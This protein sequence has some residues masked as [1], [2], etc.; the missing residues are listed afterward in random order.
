MSFK[1]SKLVKRIIFFLFFLFMTDM[2]KANFESWLTYNEGSVVETFT[3]ENSLSNKKNESGIFINVEETLEF[4]FNVP[5]DGL[6]TMVLEYKIN[7][8]RV[9]STIISISWENKEL[10]SYLPALWADESKE[11]PRDR[12]GNEIVPRQ[13]KIDNFH[14]EYIKDYSSLSSLPY[15]FELKKGKNSFKVKNISQ[16]ITIKSFTLLKYEPLQS[17]DQYFLDTPK[18]RIE[19]TN[20]YIEI[21]AEDYNVKTDSFVRP[22]NQQD[23][24]IHPY[25]TYIRK[26]NII[27]GS[28]WNKVGQRINWT[29]ELES[30]GMYYMVFRYS[31]SINEGI[32]TF[33]NIYIDGKIPFYEAT[34]YKFPYTGI[35][36]QN[37]LFKDETINKPFGIWLDKGIHTISLEVDATPLDNIIFELKRIMNDINQTGLEIKKITGGI[38]DRNRKWDME[39]YF[40]GIVQKFEN[41]ANQIDNIYNDLEIL[42]DQKPAALVNLKIASDNIR[43]LIEEPSKIPAQLSKL[44]EGFSSASNL[45]SETIDILS[46]QPLTLDRIYILSSPY[47]PEDDINLFKRFIEGI[48]RFI[49]SFFPRNKEY[50][51]ANN[52]KFDELLVWVNRPIQYVE[53]LQ[54][55]TDSDFS[56]KTGINVRFSVMPNEQ[57]LILANAANISPDIALGISNYIPYDLAIRGAVQ[58]LTEFEDFWEYISKEYNLETLIPYFVED[59]VYGV[60]ETQDFYVLFYRNDILESLNLE[61]PQT[62]EDVQLTMSTLYRNSMNFYLPMAGWTGLKPFYTTVP[63]IYQS[64]GRLYT[65]DGLKTAINEENSIKGFEI[66]TKLFTIYSVSQSVPN[67]YNEFRYGRIPLGVSNFTT[68]VMLMTAAPEIAGQWGITLS[69]GIKNEKGE[70]LRYQVGSDRADVIFANST[71]KQESWEFLKWWLSKDTQVEYA[72]RMQTRYGPEYMWNTANMAAFEELSFPE[73]H[74]KIILEQWEWIKEIPRHPAG[75]MVEREI[76]N[77]WTDVVMNGEGIRIAIDKAAITA[78]REILR[79]MEEFGYIKDEEVVR[80]YKIPTIED[81]IDEVEKSK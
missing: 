10:T 41:W 25:K 18:I 59:K 60:T 33:R 45:I 35:K 81:I 3:F 66:M 53:M 2:L 36:Y 20:V 71:K 22:G 67:F 79:K 76:S 4:T 50:M 75:Y 39:L 31:Q 24:S 37:I 40:P 74:K 51:V 29:F 55:M 61:I 5:E 32:S 16:S 69:P 38:V 26:L 70:I 1:Q 73:V 47:L 9:L 44:N 15:V 57:R 14:K 63:F 6:Y 77:A 56:Q 64:G 13:I 19:D 12:Y 54:Q 43:N 28:S 46:V 80:N 11:Y 7:S 65:D 68:Y 52:K 48:K 34:S 62:W 17:Y 30:S 58:D 49:Y 23:P 42:Y 27:D 72:Y 21:E 8:D 78:N